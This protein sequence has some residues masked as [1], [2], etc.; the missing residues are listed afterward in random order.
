MLA[1]PD[2]GIPY[3]RTRSARLRRVLMPLFILCVVGVIALLVTAA[4]RPSELRGAG[5]TLAQPLIERS[6]TA[7]RNARS[8]DNP[9]EAGRTG[10]DWRM[11]G[12]SGIDYEPVGSLGGIM[13]VERREVD[14]AISD[15]PLSAAAL[16]EKDV[17]Q[18][19]VAVGSVAVVH[20]LDLPDQHN[21]RLDATTLSEI[22]TGRIRTWNDAAIRRLNPEVTLPGQQIHVVHR[23]DGSGSTF[24]FTS[25][26]SSGSAE[27]ADGPGTNSVI[28]WPTGTGAERSSGMISAVRD[29]PGSIGYVEPGQA[30]QAGLKLTGLRNVTGQFTLPD[31]GSMNAALGEM[32]WT[33]GQRYVEPLPPARDAAAYPLTVPIY[34]ILPRDGRQT[35]A[36]LAYLSY[37]VEEYDANAEELGYLPLPG[38]AAR[39]VRAAW[40]QTFPSDD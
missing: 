21:L 28:T 7:F 23:S 27:W 20:N 26:L 13:R 32:D 34:A 40:N 8:A 17:A 18:F 16:D 31:T 10:G 1:S 38:D 3:L 36:A 9:Q 37:L 2:N 15:Y 11:D 22:Y 14:F 25:Y 5:S 39:E 29:A 6:T 4:G 19:P 12:S 35:R 24:G 33:G 30:R